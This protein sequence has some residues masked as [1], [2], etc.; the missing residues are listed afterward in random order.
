MCFTN[1]KKR[2]TDDPKHSKKWIS[3][4]KDGDIIER[5]IID[6]IYCF[7]NSDSG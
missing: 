7:L 5:Y 4:D 6:R 3:K 1:S 2:K